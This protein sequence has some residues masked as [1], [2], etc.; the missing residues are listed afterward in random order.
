[1]SYDKTVFN[2]SKKL[3]NNALSNSG[4]D[5]KMKFQ[6]LTEDKDRGHNNSRGRKIV[7]FN[8]LYSCNVAINTG[9]K[10]LLLLDKYFSK[11]RKLSKVLNCN[12][13]KVSYNFMPN[14]ASMTNA[15]T[16]RY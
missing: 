14:V 8:P 7:R 9:K 1:M 5:H 15:H 11:A 3:F 13:V 4:F 6:P 12:N 10:S 16:R 2:N